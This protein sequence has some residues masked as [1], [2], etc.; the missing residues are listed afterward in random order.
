MAFIDT[1][2]STQVTAGF[3]GGPERSTRIISLE[4]GRELR[5]ARWDYAR[6]RYTAQY[7]TFT[8]AAKNELLRAI[9]ATRGRLHAFRFKD[10]NDYTAVDQALSPAIGTSDPVQLVV[11]HSFGSESSTRLIQ[12]PLPSCVVSRDSSPITGSLDTATGLF[13]PSAPWVAGV[14]TWAGEFDVWV[15]FADDRAEFVSVSRDVWT[16]NVELI[17]VRR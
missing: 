1:R 3:T 16:T 12:A 10:W 2:L 8:T 13:T 9:H 15:R 14:H 7:G 11:T 6:H 4:N 5:N 17:E